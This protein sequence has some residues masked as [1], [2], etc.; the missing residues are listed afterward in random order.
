MTLRRV[1]DVKP[2]ATQ[3]PRHDVVDLMRA[4]EREVRGADTAKYRARDRELAAR[5]CECRDVR[6]G[7]EHCRE[8]L[9]QIVEVH[10]RL[11]NA[12]RL[13]APPEIKKIVHSAFFEPSKN[14]TRRSRPSDF[15]DRDAG[16]R[17]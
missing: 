3:P 13:D 8:Q 4:I 15:P 7:L 6:T 11:R 16:A 17:Q 14:S 12:Q 1:V 5:S 2:D 9:A 10:G